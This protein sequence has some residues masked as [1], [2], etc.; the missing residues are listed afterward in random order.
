MLYGNSHSPPPQVF[1][2][3]S[4]RC[5]LKAEAAGPQSRATE[6]ASSLGCWGAWRV[7]GHRCQDKPASRERLCVH[8]Y[9]CGCPQQ[10]NTNLKS[11]YLETDGSLV[12]NATSK[13][14][15]FLSVLIFLL[16][17]NKGFQH[18][19]LSYYCHSRT[20]VTRFQLCFS[21]A[22]YSSPSTDIPR[23]QCLPSRDCEST[24]PPFLWFLRSSNT[25]GTKQW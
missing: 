5:L 4:H 12:S 24:S 7:R 3:T 18:R 6:S 17:D 25:S 21:T 23:A 16:P 13:H 8:G 10:I 15:R 19:H 11:N 1:T 20:L 2:T 14:K 22:A 9:V